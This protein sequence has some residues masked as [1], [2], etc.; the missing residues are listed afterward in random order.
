M[1]LYGV[2]LLAG[3]NPPQGV[4]HMQNKEQIFVYRENKLHDGAC[5]AQRLRTKGKEQDLVRNI[6]SVLQL[7]LIVQC[8]SANAC[9]VSELQ[10]S[11]GGHL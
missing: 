2:Y 7:Y 8:F 3:A 6:F 1:W 10:S 5:P 4:C 9:M 11:T